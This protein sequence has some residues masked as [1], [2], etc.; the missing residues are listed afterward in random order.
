MKARLALALALATGVV[1]AGSADAARVSCKIV[2]DR[3]GDTYAVR[4]QNNPPVPAPVPM[5]PQDDSLDLLSSDLA[6][7]GKTLTAVVRVKKLART[8]QTSPFATSYNV[9]FAVPGGAGY[10]TLR[11]ILTA[12]GDSF[13][14]LSK[15]DTA[16]VP[17]TFLG[18]VKGT[19]DFKKNEVRI[20]APLSVFASFAKIKKGTKLTPFETTTGRAHPVGLP[21]PA[22]QPMPTRGLNSDVAEGGKVY[23][24]GDKTCVTVGK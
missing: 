24:V 18:S 2:T 1:V 19:V 4:Y 23:K 3:T 12:S 7:D 21:I 13:E 5:G 16:N 9:D 6:S 15:S 10:A 8:T 22:G 11:A 17:S 20:H 14:A